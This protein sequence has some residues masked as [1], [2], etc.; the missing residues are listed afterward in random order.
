MSDTEKLI[1]DNDSDNK[2]H[3][4]AAERGELSTE[5]STSNPIL[6]GKLDD[7]KL[8]KEH[9]ELNEVIVEHGCDNQKVIAKENEAVVRET[10]VEETKDKDEDSKHSVTSG[11]SGV[12]T[13]VEEIIN[14]IME[15]NEDKLNETAQG[16]IENEMYIEAI[17]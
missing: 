4:S 6:V 16:Q 11:K 9:E 14:E 15:D 12:T 5:Q 10:V 3:L 7:P 1:G 8:A 17:S 2:N 13:P